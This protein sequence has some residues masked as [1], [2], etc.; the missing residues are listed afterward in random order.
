M[1]LKIDKIKVGKTNIELPFPSGFVKV[2]D[3]MGNLLETANK[4]CPET[5]T[6]LA[7]YISEDDYANY[8]VNEN[9][10]CEKYILVEVFNELK[11]IKVGAKD[12]RQFLKKHK[13]EYI[14]EFKLQIDDAEIKASENFSKFDE[15]IKMKDFK[16]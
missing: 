3:S 14:D 16:M 11:N 10:I 15:R 7:Y 4:L 13:E 9:H 2:D 1:N 5:N 8:L 6:L 12:Y